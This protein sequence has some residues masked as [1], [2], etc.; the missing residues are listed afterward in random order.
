MRL[1]VAISLTTEV[2]GSFSA[3]LEELR[4]LAPRAK[5]VQVENLH[6]TLKFLGEVAPAKLDPIRSPLSAIR[7][8]SGVTLECRGLGFFP[9]DRNPRVFWAGVEASPNLKPLAAKIDIAMNKLGFP[10]ETRAFAPHLTLARFN[11]PVMPP[12]FRAGVA[13]KSTLNFGS[14]KAA[15]FHL[16]QSKLKSTGAEYTILQSFPFAAA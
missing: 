11:E 3:L 1:F 15:E 7:S 14:L 5:W 16:V 9:N 4:P 12:K 10:L 2:R 13:E 8:E 6:L